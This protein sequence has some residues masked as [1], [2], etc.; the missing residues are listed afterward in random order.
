MKSQRLDDL[1]QLRRVRDRMD[2]EYA[3][4][5][6]LPVDERALYGGGRWHAAIGELFANDFRILVARA[7]LEFWPHPGFPRP[8]TLPVVVE[9]WEQ[10]ISEWAYKEAPA[11]PDEHAEEP[12]P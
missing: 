7:E 1:A 12:T 8:E 10:A 9:F 11:E 2:R 4:L 3:Q 5:R 6:G